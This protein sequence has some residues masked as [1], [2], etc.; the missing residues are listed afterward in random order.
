MNC[1]IVHG[2]PSKKG[3]EKENPT[4]NKHWMPWLKKELE[5][6]NVTAKRPMLSNPWKPDYT[7]WKK[8]FSIYEKFIDKNTIL[9]GHSCGTVFLTRWLAETKKEILK[10][11]LVAPWKK[12]NR[13][14][15]RE[16]LYKYK[17]DESIKERVGKIII[18]TADDEEQI[19]KDAAKEFKEKLGAKLIELKGRGHYTLGDMGTEE[20]PELLEEILSS[21]K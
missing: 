2:C 13:D 15:P 10:L 20:F 14:D 19:G 1:I 16:E 3:F 17:I 7:L 6:N 11:I 4:Y 9:I 21:K 8:E 18:F 5:K 12:S